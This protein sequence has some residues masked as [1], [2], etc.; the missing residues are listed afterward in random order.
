LKEV[1]PG[2]SVEEMRDDNGDGKGLNVPI[3]TVVA[4]EIVLGKDRGGS[5][6]T[7]EDW[8]RNGRRWFDRTSS[9][10]SIV[11]V[12]LRTSVG[13]ATRWVVLEREN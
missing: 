5:F 1:D 11:L 2:G 8:F 13:V 4:Q 10:I 3:R 9:E 6:S 12:D 7:A